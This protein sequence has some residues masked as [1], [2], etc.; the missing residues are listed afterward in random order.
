MIFLFS[1]PPT[2]KKARHRP[3]IG[4]VNSIPHV[5]RP[6]SL[7]TVDYED[8][9]DNHERTPS[10]VNFGSTSTA[11]VVCLCRFPCA[12]GIVSTRS[13]FVASWGKDGRN[14]GRHTL[15][16][17]QHQVSLALAENTPSCGCGSAVMMS[18]LFAHGSSFFF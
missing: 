7:T 12:A 4:I 2:T 9:D 14:R 18:A 10:Q 5:N 6:P 3:T 11:V 1:R 17:V 8:E 16:N 15:V 13:S